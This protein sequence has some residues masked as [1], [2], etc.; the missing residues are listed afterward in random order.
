M[1]FRGLEVYLYNRVGSFDH[2][3]TEMERRAAEATPSQPGPGQSGF[4]IYRIFSK[5]SVPMES[6]AVPLS[7]YPPSSAAPPSFRKRTIIHRG[8][9]YLRGQLPS[10]DPK[11][12]LPLSLEVSKLIVTCGNA[13]TPNLLVFD[14]HRTE[15]IVGVVPV[16]SCMHYHVVLPDA[17]I[18]RDQDMTSTSSSSTLRC[19]RST[20]SSCQTKT[21]MVR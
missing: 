8:I 15:G 5:S 17:D 13:A 18:S 14:A 16:S 10:L 20:P 7:T 3:V 1:K 2:I 12:L 6:T 21:I 9:D 11:D 4:S 19:I